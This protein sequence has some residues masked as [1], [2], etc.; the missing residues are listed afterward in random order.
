VNAF[1]SLRQIGHQFHELL[2]SANI[3]T[4]GWIIQ[5]QAPDTSARY[6]LVRVIHQS[7][8]RLFMTAPA[9]RFANM[10]RYQIEGIVFDLGRDRAELMR[11][12]SR[13]METAANLKTLAEAIKEPLR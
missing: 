2:A 9:M 11:M 10:H 7:V 1:E 13:L 3:P 6:D 4:D 12:H 5:L 8:D